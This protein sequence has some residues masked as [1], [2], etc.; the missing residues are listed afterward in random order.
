M[1]VD[2]GARSVG[3]VVQGVLGDDN[4]LS[5]GYVMYTYPHD[6]DP[7]TLGLPWAEASFPITAGQQVVL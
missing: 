6:T 7:S 1:K 5:S 2:S 4:A 3:S